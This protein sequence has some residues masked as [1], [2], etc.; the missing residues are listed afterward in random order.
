MHSKVAV[1]ALLFAGAQAIPAGNHHHGS[2]GG[3]GPGTGMPSQTGPAGPVGTGMPSLTG[4]VGP[5]NTGGPGG[6][7]PGNGQETGMPE[8]T[9]PAGPENTGGPGGNGPGN[10]YGSLA[11]NGPE[12]GM[13]TPTGPVQHASTDEPDGVNDSCKELK[14]QGVSLSC[15]VVG[16]GAG[17][18]TAGT[19]GLPQPTGANPVPTGGYPYH[20][21]NR[22][23]TNQQEGGQGRPAC[24]IDYPGTYSLSVDAQGITQSVPAMSS[25][26]ACYTSGGEASATWSLSGAWGPTAGPT[27]GYTFPTSQPAPGY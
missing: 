6:Y 15:S 5:G 1:I 2:A 11:G 16:G 8:P 19:S 17:G 4:P 24:Y 12:T 18:P 22:A 21:R 20:R 26:E 9:G 7:G 23:H 13:P 10:P 27:G 14:A 3:N 25:K